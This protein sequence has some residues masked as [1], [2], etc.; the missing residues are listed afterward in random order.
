MYVICTLCVYV[1]A[2]SSYDDMILN[3]PYVNTYYMTWYRNAA[4]LFS[5]ISAMLTYRMADIW[6]LKELDLE[7]KHIS[8]T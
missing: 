3:I 2:D 6:F 5:L 1:H 7:K 8:V 4:K